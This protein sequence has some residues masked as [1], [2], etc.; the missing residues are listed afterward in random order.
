MTIHGAQIRLLGIVGVCG[1][2]KV[3][4]G[5]APANLLHSLSFADVLNEDTGEGYQR[6]FSQKHSLDF[7]RYIRG[8]ERPVISPRG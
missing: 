4:M 7:R 5:F 1:R 3:F 6:K 8:H 2:R